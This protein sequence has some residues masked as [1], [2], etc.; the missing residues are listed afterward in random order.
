[1]R[2]LLS[3]KEYI[4]APVSPLESAPA[5]RWLRLPIAKPRARSAVELSIV[6]L[7]SSQYSFN[8]GHRFRVYR[9]AVVASNVRKSFSSVRFFEINR[10]SAGMG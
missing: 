8:V 6:I 9:I 3:V 5:K 10:E 4:D 2:F 1:M 7:P